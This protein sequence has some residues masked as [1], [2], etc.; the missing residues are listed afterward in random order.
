[1]RIYEDIIKGRVCV[2]H[3]FVTC[4]RIHTQVTGH[5]PRSKK[6]AIYDYDFRQT[7]KILITRERCECQVLFFLVICRQLATHPDIRK[8]VIFEPFCYSFFIKTDLTWR[9]RERERAGGGTTRDLNLTIK[10]GWEVVRA[11]IEEVLLLQICTR[12]QPDIKGAI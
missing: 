4:M 2:S 3:F 1:M 7:C 5:Q 6:G 10:G 11:K 12:K 9:E 8:C